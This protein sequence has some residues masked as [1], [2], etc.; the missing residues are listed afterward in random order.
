MNDERLLQMVSDWAYTDP[1]PMDG[2]LT[3]CR[4]VALEAAAEQKERDA[5]ICEVLAAQD[6]EMSKTLAVGETLHT[7]PNWCA[8]AIRNQK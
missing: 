6:E 1:E 8:Q 7:T 5:L 3:L 2:I 4:Q